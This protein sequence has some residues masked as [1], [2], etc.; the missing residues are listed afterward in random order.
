MSN[1]VRTLVTLVASFLAVALWPGRAD[2]YPWMIRHEY[3]NCIA[4]HVDPSGGGLLTPY[5]R[6]QS[7]VLLSTKYSNEEVNPGKFIFFAGFAELP[8]SVNLGAWFRTGYIS[9]GADA[10]ATTP[11]TRQGDL[12]AMRYDFQGQFTL[13][14]VKFNISLGI[15]PRN[16]ASGQAQGAYVTRRLNA[17]NGLQREVQLVSREHW[18]GYDVSDAIMLRAGRINLPFGLR[19]FEHNAWVRSSTRTDYN[20]QQQHGITASYGD[21]H[22]RG[23]IMAILGNYQIAPDGYRERGYSG[24][25]EFAVGQY[26][27]VGFSSLMTYAKIDQTGKNVPIFRQAHGPYTRYTIAKPVVLLAEVDLL[28]N[29][30]QDQATRVGWTG[31]GQFDIEP[32]QGVHILATGEFLRNGVNEFSTERTNFGLWGGLWWFPIPHLDVRFDAIRRFG[33]NNYQGTTTYLAQL[34]VYL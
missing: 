33:P 27:A 28:A 30:F 29:S 20:T 8:N 25:V 13:D 21:E 19:N 32:V 14:K 1:V 4:C 34:H 3:N 7:Q 12:V 16:E 15:S 24:Y 5:G 6:G 31:F 18:V 22:V 26:Q 2:A 23:E 11:A 9:R 17:Q 10:T